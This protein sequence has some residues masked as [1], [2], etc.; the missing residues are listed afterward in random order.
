M[1]LKIA[2]D[3]LCCVG[4]TAALDTLVELPAGTKTCPTCGDGG[5]ADAAATWAIMIGQQL[6]ALEAAG[7]EVPEEGQELVHSKIY[8]RKVTT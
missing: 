2:A 5:L 8:E 7:V 3:A 6:T 4:C 1:S